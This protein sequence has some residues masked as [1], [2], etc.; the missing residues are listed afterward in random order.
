MTTETEIKYAGYIDQQLRQMEKLRG[1]DTRPIPVSMTF[2]AIPGISREVAE[3][4]TKV[5]PTTLGQASRI[6]G[7]TAAAMAILDLHLT[8]ACR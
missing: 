8:L 4:L 2:D 1:S 6:P 3:K 5:R 7:V